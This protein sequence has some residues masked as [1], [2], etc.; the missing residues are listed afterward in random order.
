MLPQPA[1]DALP[2]AGS[3]R[4]A[5]AFMLDMIA[6][7]VAAAAVKLLLH[8]GFGIVTDLDTSQA[9]AVLNG[10]VSQ[11]AMDATHASTYAS[12]C[13]FLVYF[14]TFE[15]SR[16]GASPGKL[17]LGLALTDLDGH[18]VGPFRS[19]LRWMALCIMA[20]FTLGASVLP[21]LFTKKRQGLHDMMLRTTVVRRSGALR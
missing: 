1:N 3:G 4:R 6:C 5:A 17:A 7:G 2:Y 10:H 13:T 11:A 19:A 21:A 8:A 12:V 16:L 20:T 15:S 9:T 14:V 18:H